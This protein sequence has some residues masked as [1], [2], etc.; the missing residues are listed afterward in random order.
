MVDR[1]K[2]NDL[3]NLLKSGREYKLPKKQIL[4]SSIDRPIINLVKSGF[5]KRYSITNDGAIGVQI[6]YGPG[7]VFPL[8][9]VYKTLFNQPLYN[10][11]EVFYYET[12]SD[13]EVY[14]IDTSTL[15]EAVKANPKLYADLMQESGRHLLSCVHSLENLSLRS[16]YK[17]V[18]H[19][20][21]FFSREFGKK[22]SKGIIIEAPLTHQDIADILSLTRETVSTS[23]IKLRK[24]GF[25][26]TD[27]SILVPDLAKLEAEAFS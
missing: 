15:Q 10:G 14:S 21:T 24:G 11:P 23:V 13:T 3:H 26:K 5:I 7:D 22:T 4:Q 18:A 20:L 16:S 2:N 1:Q 9:L 19:Q 6:T 12:M 27:K 17:R 25:I 8:T